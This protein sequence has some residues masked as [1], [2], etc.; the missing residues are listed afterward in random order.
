M[1]AITQLRY[2]IITSILTDILERQD[3]KKS[4]LSEGKEDNFK[5]D[6]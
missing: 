1:L 6:F 4:I 5:N 2:L 3:A